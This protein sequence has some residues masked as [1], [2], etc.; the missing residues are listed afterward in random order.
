MGV[1]VD[2]AAVVPVIEKALDTVFIYLVEKG[3]TT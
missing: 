2:E 1:A 3:S